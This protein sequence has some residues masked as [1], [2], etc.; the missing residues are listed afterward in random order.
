MVDQG[1]RFELG[2][3]VPVQQSGPDRVTTH[4][5]GIR[6]FA[7]RAEAIGLDTIWTDAVRAFRDAGFTQL[8][9]M[10]GS[11]AIEALEALAPV[12]EAIH[13]D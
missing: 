13:A 9:F 2:I 7:L 11:G 3:V 10:P 4:W 5:P 6:E 8:E 1:G 12:V